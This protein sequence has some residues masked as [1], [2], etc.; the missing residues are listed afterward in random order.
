MS[1]II[2]EESYDDYLGRIYF[3]QK[4]FDKNIFNI[5][6][7]VTDNCNLQCSYCYQINKG[8]HKMNIDIAKKFIDMLLDNNEHTKA[9][10][11][12]YSAR[13]AVL[14]FIGGEPFLEVQ[15]IDEIIEYFVE[16]AILKNHPWQYNYRISISTNGTLYF[17]PEVQN[18]IK[19]Y[20]NH[21]SLGITV[22]GHKELHDSCRI[23]P[24]GTGSYDLAISAVHHY[25]DIH[26]GNINSKV[27]LAPANIKYTSQALI[28]LIK[29]GY[30]HINCNCV[31]EKGWTLE[32]AKILY[33]ELTIV[34]DYLLNNNLAETHTISIFN[35]SMF[36]PIPIENT[37]NWCG[38]NGR[39]IA[40][41]YKGD[42]YPCVR[43]MESSLGNSIPPII[44]GNVNNGIMTEK[45]CIECAQCLQ[46]VNRITQSTEE[47]INCSIAQ[48]CAWC[49]AY[50]YQDSGDFNHR[51]T[52]ICLM[53]QARALAN[54][55]YWN[56][57]YIQN[58]K[59]IRMK[60]Y[61]EDEKALQIISNEEL[62]ILKLLQ[63]IPE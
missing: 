51:A 20:Q 29:E 42:I 2:K 3:N 30:E 41:D 32:H 55:Y 61:L 35:E 37:E 50:N 14:D 60:L 47:C 63:F 48:G 4:D 58:N 5:T 57:Y 6:F 44:I 27:T 16:Q 43:Y 22:D 8:C 24:D 11:D 1:K 12:T 34:A 9:Y 54:C 19:K 15:L 25:H 26:K 40:V 18:F 21:L 52:Y 49:Q 28:H 62:I 7:Q 33:Q 17:T 36:C 23:F 46:A 10:I 59:D 38:G 45:K 53:H 39:M 13:A 56:Q 31:F